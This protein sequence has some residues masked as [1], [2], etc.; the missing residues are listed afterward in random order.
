MTS[1]SPTIHIV[2]DDA[3]FRTAIRRVLYSLYLRQP[4]NF[5]NPYAQ[6]IARTRARYTFS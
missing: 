4:N 5:T 3:P 1:P 2:D 6:R